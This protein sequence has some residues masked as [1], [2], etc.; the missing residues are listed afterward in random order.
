MTSNGIELVTEA[1]P[2]KPEY[3]IVGDVIGAAGVLIGK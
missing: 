3:L 1:P 2:N